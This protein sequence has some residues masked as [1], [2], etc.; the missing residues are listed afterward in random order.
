MG[1]ARLT[2]FGVALAVIAAIL[3]GASPVEAKQTH[4]FL[5]AFGSTNQPTF[6]GP[7]DLAVDPDTGDLL[8]I[9]SDDKTISRWNPDGTAANFS[10]LGTNVID[11]KGAGDGTPESGFRFASYEQQIAIDN[12][13]GS[14]DGDIYVSQTKFDGSLHLIDIFAPSGEFLG[15]IT[16]LGGTGFGSGNTPCG[17]AVDASGRLF[18]A[19]TLQSSV[20]MFASNGAPH[21]PLNNSDYEKTFTNITAPCNLAAGM[22]STSGFLFIDKLV[23]FEGNSVVRLN[24]TVGKGEIVDSGEYRL[25][26]VN[27]TNGHLFAAGPIRFTPGEDGGMVK[28]FDASALLPASLVSSFVT[29][30]PALTYGIAIDGTGSRIY[31]AKGAGSIGIYGPLATLPDVT[32]DLTEITGDTSARLNGKVDPDGEALT[33]CFF[34]YLSDATYQANPPSNRFA[35]ATPIPCEEPDATE[36]GEGHGAVEVHAD[37]EGLGT[38]TLY[39]FRLVAT[40][41]N[42]ALYP[43]DPGSTVRGIERTFKTPSKPDIKEAW[44]ASVGMDEAMVKAKINPGNSETTYRVQYGP[45]QTYGQET[46]VATVAVGID[47]EDHVVSSV[48]KGLTE[49]TG[50]HFRFLAENSIGSTVGDDRTFQTFRQGPVGM[51]DLRAYELVSP[52]EKEGGEA[53]TTPPAGGAGETRPRQAS[54]SGDAFT[55]GSFTAFGE[56]PQSASGNSQY[57]SSREPGGWLTDNINPPFEE[58]GLHGPFVGFSTDL[59]H[60]AAYVKEPELTPDAAV[61]VPN[62]YWRDNTIGSLIAITTKDH[63]PQIA[64]E[65]GYCLSY[66]GASADSQRVFFAAKAGLLEEDPVANSFNLY[67]WAANRPANQRLRLLSVLP[68]E[69][70]AAPSP[71]AGTGFGAGAGSLDCQV[72]NALMRH[73]V[74]SNG[75]RVFWTYD[76]TYEGATD[77]LFA[78]VGGTETVRLDQPNEGVT[79][80]GGGGR[81]WD[82]SLNGAKVFFTDTKRLT[83]GSTAVSEK[84]DIYRYDFAAPEGAR[85]TDLA[86]PAPVESENIQANVQGVVGA[87]TDGTFVYFVARGALSGEEENDTGEKAQPGQDNLY[88][89][90]EGD[91]IG[92]I[93][94]LASSDSSNWASTPTQQTARVASDGHHLAFLSV[95]SLTGSEN[96]EGNASA[97]GTP[98]GLADPCPEVFLYD[99]DAKSI[100]CASCNPSES[101]PLGPATLAPWN[102]PYEQP[103]YLSD[104]GS[105][106]LFETLD[107]LDPHDVNSESD[108][109][110]FEVQGAGSCKAASPTFVEDSGGCIFLISTGT[111]EDKSYFLDASSDGEDLFLST[112]ER[113]WPSVDKDKGFDVY[114]ARIGGFSEPMQPPRCSGQCPNH[115]NETNPPAVPAPGTEGFVGPG[116]PNPRPPCP[117]GKRR[118]S[119]QGRTRCVPRKRPHPKRHKSAAHHKR[120]AGR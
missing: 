39:R 74:S 13:G 12:S 83:E 95:K 10:A 28:E 104:D 97:C 59:S 54:P 85:L 79:G 35:G 118:V 21:S 2:A 69:S 61:D 67:E 82:A 53:G 52:S 46:S 94:T 8:V 110:E 38:E 103:R 29:S 89:W 106:L 55:F 6:G 47:A 84:P 90:H 63:Q 81:Y 1:S 11:A 93:A 101:R 20:Y 32:T 70:P 100:A 56:S 42:A 62:L 108:V 41:A 73:A 116:N 9:D 7:N 16:G 17:V 112:R 27:P 88:V 91:G 4:L 43:N 72:V 109:Y 98:T 120:R 40:N 34:Q 23:T 71:S 3:V 44:A 117:K 75:S 102:T 26:S 48:L 15:Q 19:D 113:L 50:Y 66:G 37:V 64:P 22:G 5:E 65:A 51:P 86:A 114:D 30:S 68:D 57:L 77:P 87:S 18:V 36:V 111:D 78:R 96:I 107:A 58:G 31:V 105:R 92:F 60:A 45:T 14:T 25:V 115:N 80:A 49:G 33:S 24:I 99:S 119:R 76:G